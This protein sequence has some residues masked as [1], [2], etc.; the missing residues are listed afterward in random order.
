MKKATETKAIC[1][2][3]PGK[4][5]VESDTYGKCDVIDKNFVNEIITELLIT[6]TI[7]P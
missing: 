2:H 6:E 3:N 1:K 4:S 5:C 7:D